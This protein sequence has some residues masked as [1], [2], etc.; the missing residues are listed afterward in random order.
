MIQLDGLLHVGNKV[1]EA[2]MEDETRRTSILHMV[3]TF[4]KDLVGQGQFARLLARQGSQPVYTRRPR[5]TLAAEFKLVQHEAG[6]FS[7][8]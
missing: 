2:L 7:P 8:R 5:H 1:D 3:S 4:V 6:T